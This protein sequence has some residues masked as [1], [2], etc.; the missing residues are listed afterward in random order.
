V[1]VEHKDDIKN[2]LLITNVLLVNKEEGE[3]ILGYPYGEKNVEEILRE[4]QKL[5]PKIVIVTD[6]KNGSFAI[7]SEGKILTEEIIKTDV[8][9]KTGA[10]DAY[11]SGFISALIYNKSIAEAMLWGAKNSASVIGQ[12]GAQAGLLRKNDLEN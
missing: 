3:E 9:E 11:S 7:D 2:V 8:V 12:V 4:L 6:G 1:Q 5:G 10:G